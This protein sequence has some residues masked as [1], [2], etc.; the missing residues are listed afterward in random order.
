[1]TYISDAGYSTLSSG[2]SSTSPVGG[3]TTTGSNGGSISSDDTTIILTSASSFSNGQTIKIESEYIIIGTISTNTLNGCTRGAFNSTGATHTDGTTVIG[4]FVG[5]ADQSPQ[6]DVMVSLKSTTAGTEYF[7]FSNNGS[8]WDTFPVTG[9]TVTANIHEFHT[10]VK[11]FRYFR[12]RFEN[13]S[14]SASTF[15]VSTYYG[16]FR[17]GNLPLNQ[18]IGADSDSTIVRSVNVGQEPNGTYSNTK[19]SGSAF[20]TTTNLQATTV[21]STSTGTNTGNKTVTS[22]SNFFQ[23]GGE[24]TGY[25]Y[26]GSEF[27]ACTVIDGTTLNFTER[28]ALGTTANIAD[29]QTGTVIGE[30]YD[31]GVLTL[32]GYTEVATKVLCDT[33][34]Q[35]RLQ[36]YS[37]SAGTDAIRTLAP[38]YPPSGGVVGDYDYLGAPNFG[39]YVRYLIAN[40]DSGGSATTDIYFETEFYTQ[41]ISAQVLTVNSTI[42]PPM[43][44][45]LTRAIIAGQK[46]DTNYANVALDESSNLN[47]NINSSLTAFDDISVANAMPVEQVKFVYGIPQNVEQFLSPGTYF[48]VGTEG[49][50]STQ[51]VQSIY[52]PKASSFASS[53]A[54][55]Y[56]TLQDGDGNDMYVWFDIDDG[57]SDP[58]P[59]GTGIQVDITSVDSAAGVA[60]AANTA[61]DANAAFSSSAFGNIVTI[62]NANNTAA[63]PK[64]I[65]ATNMPTTSN[66][67]ITHTKG[68]P[69]CNLTVG[70]GVGDYAVLRGKRQLKYNP[71][72]GIK[73]RLAAVFDTAEANLLQYVGVSNSTNGL[74]IGY[75]GTTFGIRHQYGGVHAVKTLTVTDVGGA[76][77]GNITITIDGADF[78]ITLSSVASTQAVAQTIGATDFT[79]ALYNVDVVDSSVI[80]ISHRTT[81][82]TGGSKNTG[83]ATF[84]YTDTGTTGVAMAFQSDT[85]TTPN[86]SVVESTKTNIAQSSFNVDSLDGTGPSGMT[87]SPTTGNVYQIQYQWLGFG[88]IMFSVENPNNGRLF[89]CHVIYPIGSFTTPSLNQPDMQLAGF[90]ST[91]FSGVSSKTLKLASLAGFMEGKILLGEPFFTIDNVHTSISGAS[92]DVILASVRNPR[93]FMGIT[94]QVVIRLKTMTYASS[95]SANNTKASIRVKIVIGGTPSSTLTYTYTS[96]NVYTPTYSVT[97][98]VGT[99][100]SGGVIVFEGTLPAEGSNV[101]RFIDQNI[102]LDKNEI[103][104]ITYTNTA[105][106]TGNIDIEAALSWTEFH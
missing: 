56:F 29:H 67:T 82:G 104:Y 50:I 17:Q 94:S 34:A 36:W 47:V 102:T 95:K 6:P 55:D 72:V 52:L 103:M 43:T 86:T 51:Q 15:R 71:G 65:D 25:I 101:I 75:N 1:M 58:S 63:N 90:I 27:I 16:V 60:S 37:D 97:P 61:I 48:T 78:L 38:S 23:S 54:A 83:A 53:G 57:N 21:F 84:G 20:R 12:I 19:Q 8:T 66:S 74:Y 32:E 98:A 4:V 49:D 22:T 14:S 7:D 89:P 85:A 73:A 106:S 31:S 100:L 93:T 11:G 10:A 79:S 39:P 80:F 9:F 77:T 105:P 45:N 5:T 87:I 46:P 88:K 35:L 91:A 24:S 3:Q 42:L 44:T 99:T 28:G 96:S 92:T 33:T 30:A 2:N 18:S 64:S 59:G 41:A 76:S 68:T 81:D 70:T 40:T 62:T 26:I 69:M 13:G